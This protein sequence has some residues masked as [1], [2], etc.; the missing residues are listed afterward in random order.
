MR[1]LCV[2]NIYII[3]LAAS[4][5]FFVFLAAL[6][7]SLGSW[8]LAAGLPLPLLLLLFFFLVL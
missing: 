5:N 4:F 1:L 8:L 6:L 2:S 3:F 7:P